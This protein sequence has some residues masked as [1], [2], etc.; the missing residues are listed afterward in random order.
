MINDKKN[1]A[2]AQDFSIAVMA[3]VG[4]SI[5]IIKK[6]DKSW[7]KI[8]YCIADAFGE[9]GRDEFHAISKE[10]I[11][12]DKRATDEKYDKCLNSLG[13]YNI[14]MGF[15]FFKANQEFYSKTGMSLRGFLRFVHSNK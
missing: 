13:K 14:N 8:G 12:Y 15:F 11:P 9:D 7:F 6:D 1:Y 10:C 2:I 5:D 4:M 3:I